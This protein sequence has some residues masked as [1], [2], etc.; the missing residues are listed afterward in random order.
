MTSAASRRTV[1]ERKSA[2]ALRA[3]AEQIMRVRESPLLVMFYPD[4]DLE[5]EEEQIEQLHALLR[6]RGLRKSTP[7]DALDVL[8][9]TR[10]GDPTAAY[11]LA[12]VIRNFANRVD[13]LVPEYAYSAGTIVCL[14][15]ESILMG[16]YAV[17]SPIDITVYPPSGDPDE[18]PSGEDGDDEGIELVALDHFIKAAVRARIEM[19]RA[20][21]R[22]GLQ[23][24]ESSVESEMLTA[25]VEELDAIEIGHLYRQRDLTHVYAKELLASYMFAGAPESDAT[26]EKILSRLIFD[27]PSHDFAMDYHICH[28]AGLKVE[29]MD[30]A[31][32]DC[33]TELTKHLQVM[34]ERRLICKKIRGT[35]L[36]FFDLFVPE[37]QG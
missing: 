8:V 25:M 13:F 11:R 6:S 1:G 16:D 22:E 31:L 10:G 18:E 33:S 24:A 21:E 35:R 23:D 14:G 20:F 4:D 7:L 27:A 2:N 30:E 34:A 9:H 36:P 29:E 19:E 28:D 5:I 12:Q 17:L 37:G 3:L 32:S 26:I 15:G